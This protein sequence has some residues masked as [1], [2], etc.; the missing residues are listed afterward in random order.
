[1][2]DKLALNRY[3]E[4]EEPEKQMCCGKAIDMSY[5]IYMLMGWFYFQ[6]LVVFVEGFA[7][8]YADHWFGVHIILINFVYI[9]LCKWF[10]V[11]S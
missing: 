7:L 2:N 11:W 5:G 1:M 4:P 3:S 8:L 6:T 9:F 10:Y